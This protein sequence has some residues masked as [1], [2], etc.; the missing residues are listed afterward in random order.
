MDLNQLK[1]VSVDEFSLNTGP[2]QMNL[3]F[4]SG[5]ETFGFTLNPI[6]AKL[7]L[8]GLKEAVDMLERNVGEI[9]VS[10]IQKQIISPIQPK[11]P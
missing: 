9:N 11:Q 6:G 1:K 8:N 7:L 5:S 4:R 3:G 10:D 2:F